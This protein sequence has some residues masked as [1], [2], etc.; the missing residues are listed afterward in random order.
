ML[1]VSDDCQQR[2]RQA[3]LVANH[4]V[5]RLWVKIGKVI[6]LTVVEFDLLSKL[7]GISSKKSSQKSKHTWVNIW[8]IFLVICVIGLIHSILTALDPIILRILRRMG[9]D[10]VFV[11][12]MWWSMAEISWGTGQ[13]HFRELLV[14][15]SLRG[16]N[17]PER[18]GGDVGGI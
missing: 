3:T 4:F 1:W 6:L 7:H 2:M 17:V 10:V 14:L 13:A 11:M 16:A 18:S 5:K 15:L 8:R 12:R 9:S